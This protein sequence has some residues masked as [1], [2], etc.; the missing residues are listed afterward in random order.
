MLLFAEKVRSCIA[1]QPD[2]ELS[3]F[4]TEVVL[5]G[6]V[7]IGLAQLAFLIF[8]AIQCKGEVREMERCVAWDENHQEY[9]I[10]CDWR[11]C[12][13]TLFAQTGLGMMVT[14]Y[15]GVKIISGLA[16]K[17][18]LDKHIVQTKKIVA[19]DLNLVEK[20]AKEEKPDSNMET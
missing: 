4:L 19:M 17:R 9:E 16:P 12:N 2:Q 13:R 6:G 18:I 7:F 3:D 20:P 15:I 8:R 10:K 14:I 5:K 1:R 11:Q